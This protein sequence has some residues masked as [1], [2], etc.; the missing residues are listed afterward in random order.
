MTLANHKG[1]GQYSE[2]ISA[3][4][5]KTCAS[6]SRVVWG[7]LDLKRKWR[8]SLSAVIENKCKCDLWRVGRE[9][10]GWV[11]KPAWKIKLG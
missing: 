4:R 8:E 10:E 3:K 6:G 7:L 5:G 11:S 1:D 2:P 9:G